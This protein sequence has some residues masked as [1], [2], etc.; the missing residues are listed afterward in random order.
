MATKKAQTAASVSPDGGD[1][2]G[3]SLPQGNEAWKIAKENSRLVNKP[4]TLSKEMSQV[5]LSEIKEGGE[6][7]EEQYFEA[8][9]QED[10]NDEATFAIDIHASS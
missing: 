7:E 9:D 1:A 6:E 10:S 2:C 4:K 3:A 5:S 8:H